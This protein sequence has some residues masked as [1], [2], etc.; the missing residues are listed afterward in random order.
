MYL[1]HFL[2]SIVCAKYHKVA[3]WHFLIKECWAL[4]LT[5]LQAWGGELV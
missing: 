4:S 1:P 3:K 5:L 2:G